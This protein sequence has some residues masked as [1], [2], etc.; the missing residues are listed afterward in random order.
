MVNV[1][2]SIIIILALLAIAVGFLYCR[3]NRKYKDDIIKL[4]IRQDLLPE[5]GAGGPWIQG[6]DCWMNDGT[7]GKVK[8]KYCQQMNVL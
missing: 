4:Q 6:G 2:W 8:G 7:I 1:H 3:M 5:P